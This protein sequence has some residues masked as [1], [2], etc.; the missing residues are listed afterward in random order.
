VT[1]RK[2]RR[3]Y[4]T[5]LKPVNIIFRSDVICSEKNLSCFCW[6]K[7]VKQLLKQ[8]CLLGIG[9]TVVVCYL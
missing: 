9:W 3:K 4:P 5:A 2:H 7:R 6:N 1:L 8:F